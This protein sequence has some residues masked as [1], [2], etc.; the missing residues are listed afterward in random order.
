VQ[1]SVGVSKYC[2]VLRCWEYLPC[3]AHGPAPHFTAGLHAKSAAEISE[4][5]EHAASRRAALQAQKV[6]TAAKMADTAPAHQRKNS[7][8][9][10]SK[11]EVDASLLAAEER[12]KH[13]EQAKVDKAASMADTDAAR[14]R[15]EEQPKKQITDV[16]RGNELPRESTNLRG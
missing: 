5:D 7:L 2:H 11:E 4:A 13:L 16:P 8:K 1:E 12:R 10:T 3:A 9:S 6:A 14:K 15:K